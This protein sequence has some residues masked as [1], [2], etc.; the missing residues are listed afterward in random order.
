MQGAAVESETNRG[1]P[2]RAF[3]RRVGI[4]WRHS[5]DEVIAQALDLSPGGCFVRSDLPLAVGDVV[6]VRLELG[7][8]EEITLFARVSH[9]TGAGL[10][11]EF[12]DATAEDRSAIEAAC[13]ALP[14]PLPRGT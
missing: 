9:R 6:I 11:L 10:G 2:R 7:G 4:V 5:D 12:L 1:A 8:G 13:R 14:P 3:G